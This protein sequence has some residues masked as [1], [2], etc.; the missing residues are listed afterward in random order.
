MII[1]G[2]EVGNCLPLPIPLVSIGQNV[3]RNQMGT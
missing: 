3:G 1:G 2:A